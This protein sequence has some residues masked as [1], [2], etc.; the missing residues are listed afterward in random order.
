MQDA[1]LTHPPTYEEMVLTPEFFDIDEVPFASTAEGADGQ[2]ST[3]PIPERDNSSAGRQFSI[4]INGYG[5]VGGKIEDGQS[6]DLQ[7]TEPDFGNRNNVPDPNLPNLVTSSADR[8]GRDSN[9]DPIGAVLTGISNENN[10]LYGSEGNDVIR[11]AVTADGSSTDY[12]LGDLG[13]DYIQ[14]QNGNDWLFGQGGD[15]LIVGGAG[16]D[17]IYGGPGVDTLFGDA[18]GE[19]LG[20]A[21]IF[22]LRAG[23]GTD[24]IADF[25]FKA[26]KFLL[27]D[28]LKFDDILVEAIRGGAILSYIEAARAAGSMALGAGDQVDYPDFPGNITTINFGARITDTRSGEALAFV[29]STALE[30][31]GARDNFLVQP[32]VS[33]TSLTLSD[34]V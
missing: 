11:G 21:N 27:V 33:R 28:G 20:G 15:D 6:I 24:L 26:D 32:G 12:I 19:S 14:G 9:G 31:L 16:D 7:P 2:A 30:L 10:L 29:E 18:P 25:E 8:R 5:G 34:A 4:Q 17:I 3:R 1:V 22:A 23:E 13:N